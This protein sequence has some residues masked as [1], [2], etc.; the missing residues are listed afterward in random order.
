MENSG[1][2]QMKRCG[3]FM[4]T[5]V[6]FV[7]FSMF[8]I[9]FIVERSTAKLSIATKGIR[10]RIKADASHLGMKYAEDWLISSVLSDDDFPTARGASAGSDPLAQIEAVR[11]DGSAARWNPAIT[12]AD[13]S[14]YIADA[15]YEPGLFTGRLASRASTPFIPR[16]PYL[17]NGNSICRFYFLRSFSVG[18]DGAELTNEELLAVSMDYALRTVEVKRL[19]YRC[20]NNPK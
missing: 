3:F 19:F 1:Q 4:P 20:R 10:N 2:A 17:E 7:L 15:D 16:M 5:V 12:S 8:A 18:E 11:R 14:I 9:G 13:V 6:F